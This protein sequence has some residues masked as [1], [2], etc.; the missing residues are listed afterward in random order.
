MNVT[1]WLAMLGG[2]EVADEGRECPANSRGSLSITVTRHPF[3]AA[4]QA[5][6]SP[7]TPPP[8]MTIRD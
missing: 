3:L 8:T 7:I 6:S 1:P 2:D 5:A 4:A